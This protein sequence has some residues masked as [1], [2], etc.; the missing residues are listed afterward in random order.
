MMRKRIRIG[1]RLLPAPLRRKQARTASFCRPHHRE[2]FASSRTN[3]L[4]IMPPSSAAF[5]AHS[6]VSVQMEISMS[7][8]R[9][10]EKAR[11][12]T[13]FLRAVLKPAVCEFSALAV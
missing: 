4:R 5:E 13:I 6:P 12:R 9:V 7:Q 11:R 10:S 3:A 1:T 8:K 2:R